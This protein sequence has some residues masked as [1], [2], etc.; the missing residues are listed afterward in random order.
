[1]RQV[2]GG[3]V[4][5]ITKSFPG[6]QRWPRWSPDSSQIAFY[7]EGSIYIVPAFGGAP[8]R[9]IAGGPKDSA[10]SPDW[11]PDGKRIAYVQNEAVHIFMLETEKSAKIIDAKEPHCLSWAPDGS[12]I[13]YVSGNLSFLFSE[14]DISE[15]IWPSIGNLAP[16]SIHIVSVLSGKTFSVT[17][18]DDLNVGPVWTPDGKHLLFVSDRGG[19]RDIYSLSL[20]SSGKPKAQ[21]KRLTTGLDA[22]TISLS[23][24]GRKL[25][26]SVFN[27]S[28]NIGYIEVP[29]TGYKSISAAKQVTMGNQIIE[30]FNVSQDGQWLA[31]SSD[32]SGNA[33]IYKMPTSGGEAT[34][35]TTHPSGDFAPCWSNDGEKIIFHSFRQG[36]RDLYCMTKDGGSI[37]QLTNDPSH[38]MESEWISDGS[39]I[40]FYSDRTGRFEVYVM[41]KNAQGWSKPEQITFDGVIFAAVSPSGNSIA[42]T[43]ENSLKVVSLEDKTTETLVPFQNTPSF[44]IPKYPIFSTDGKT[45]YYIAKDGQGNRSIRSIPVEGGEP[46]LKIVCDDQHIMMALTCF[47]TCGKRFYFGARVNE[48]NVWIMDLINK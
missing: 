3:R 16:S 8:K 22:H 43:S 34:Q 9:I 47:D 45:I 4:L 2:S 7:S 27:Y 38:E 17:S 48:S 5:E 23:Q 11:S 30:N 35:L 41:S 15:C 39:K 1:V 25:G 44:P 37:Q 33:D 29:E 21:P 18:V 46:E 40:L 14:M 13:A 20:D 32:L 28:S 24:D 31:Y 42:Y 26:Y 19:A 12:Q 6:N 10:H 36:N